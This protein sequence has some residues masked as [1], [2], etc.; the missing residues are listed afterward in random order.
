MEKE[1]VKNITTFW[2]SAELVYS[3]EDYTSATILYFKSLFVLLDY[4][5]YKSIGQTPKDHTERF[6]L[7]EKSNPY[8]YMLIDKYFQVYRDTYSLAISKE[9]CEEIRENVKKIIEEQKI[10]V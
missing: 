4:I 8:L 9:R 1:L 6:R 3:T 7:L 2:K 5:L 10:Q